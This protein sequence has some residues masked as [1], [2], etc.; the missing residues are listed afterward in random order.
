MQELIVYMGYRHQRRAIAGEQFR[1]AGE[2]DKSD[3][4]RQY[5]LWAV[6]TEG[7]KTVN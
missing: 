5:E 6:K 7:H 2:H 1:D 3:P 4:Q